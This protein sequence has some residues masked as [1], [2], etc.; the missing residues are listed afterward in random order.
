MNGEINF[1]S[2][3]FLGKVELQKFQELNK[4]FSTDLLK[5]LVGNFGLVKP[6]KN[7]QGIGVMEIVAGSGSG[8]LTLKKGA[9][10][11][12]SFRIILVE[13][14]QVDTA[15]VPDDGVD[16]YVKIKY[17]EETYEE[18]TISIDASGNV[19]GTN[20]KFT[21]LLRG[22]A[23][24]PSVVEID[25]SNN[26]GDYQVVTVTNDTTMVL[27]GTGFTAESG[28]RFR[29]RG[30]FSPGV[31]PSASE[32]N[33]FRYVSYQLTIE[34]GTSLDAGEHLLAKVNYDSGGAGLVIEDARVDFFSI[35][36]DDVI[37]TTTIPNIGIE[38]L[39]TG[40]YDPE[41]NLV[42]TEKRITRF[43]WGLICSDW[44]GSST[45]K[46]ITISTGKGGH[47]T[48]VTDV[49]NDDFNGFYA[50]FPD[51]TRAKIIDTVSGG[52]PYIEL[53]H[54]PESLP[55]SSV[56]GS[57]VVFIVPDCDKVEIHIS[58][59]SSTGWEDGFDGDNGKMEQSFEFDAKKCYGVGEIVAPD[60]GAFY[61]KYRLIKNGKV[62]AVGVPADHNYLNESAFN[63]VGEYSSLNQSSMT[64]GVG[65]INLLVAKR[66]GALLPTLAADN[67]WTG[68]QDF[69]GKVGMSQLFSFSD[70]FSGIS[71]P[72][73]GLI[74]LGA[75]Q[76][77]LVTNGSGY[78]FN[79]FVADANVKSGTIIEVVFQDATIIALGSGSSVIDAGGFGST[80]ARVLNGGTARFWKRANNNWVLLG[81]TGLKISAQR[82]YPACMRIASNDSYLAT[83]EV[84]IN[85]DDV[86]L[87]LESTV[88]T[89]PTT[90]YVAPVTGYYRVSGNIVVQADVAVISTDNFSL[91]IRV[92]GGPTDFAVARKLQISNGERIN[93]PFDIIVPAIANDDIRVV[94]K[95]SSVNYDFTIVTGSHV[96]ISKIPTLA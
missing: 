72:V 89:P 53:E 80:D 42:W 67:D 41:L 62:T 68:E 26:T 85:W 31:V 55:Q 4:D 10:I 16:Y 7:N 29:V 12:S 90:D 46:R 54:Y 63:D 69:Q 11:D 13:S 64:S 24:A 61:M 37:G 23:D 76:V 40:G 71:L 57:N 96:N 86:L 78:T 34:A 48:S 35:D 9:L 22:G 39:K 27:Q 47:Y 43:G 88:A 19:T 3:L 66:P 74:T 60:D 91:F 94:L 79:G 6:R 18:G 65:S 75:N 25:S 32:K 20:T 30:T 58:N 93:L 92:E 44:S 70:S 45:Q 84:E 49:S 36:A 59:S 15:T 83:S 38:A 56:S 82:T 17:A 50:Y 81:G 8:A 77:I 33:P 21:E 14:D 87:D 52:T 28:K 95:T 5:T 51:G 2:D 1:A 73:S